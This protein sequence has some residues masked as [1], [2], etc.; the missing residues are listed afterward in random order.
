MRALAIPKKPQKNSKNEQSPLSEERDSLSDA[1]SHIQRGGWL[2]RWWDGH[3][4]GEPGGITGKCPY[5][6]KGLWDV[7]QQGPSDQA[8]LSQELWDKGK[9]CQ[10]L[11]G[12]VQSEEPCT[13]QELRTD[14]CVQLIEMGMQSTHL[15]PGGGGVQN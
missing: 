14:E 9:D 1:S 10:D 5:P 6:Q 8:V 12:K 15:A 13:R 7:E 2:L 3:G 4:D 11:P